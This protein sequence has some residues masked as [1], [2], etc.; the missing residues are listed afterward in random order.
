M[1]SDSACFRERREA[2]AALGERPARVDRARTRDGPGSARTPRRDQGP[3]WDEF[4]EG[5][6]HYGE[7]EVRWMLYDYG[8]SCFPLR[9]LEDLWL[10]EL[11]DV[12][13][14]KVESSGAP[15]KAEINHYD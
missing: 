11:E 13:L 4:E 7:E 6:P 14:S 12:R 9:V 15:P 3:F 5:N 1:H 10:Q 2:L 8:A